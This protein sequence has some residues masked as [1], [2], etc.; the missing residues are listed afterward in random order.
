MT[1]SS[2]SQLLNISQGSQGNAS[3]PISNS[4]TYV[5]VLGAAASP[6]NATYRLTSLGNITAPSVRHYFS[7]MLPCSSQY[8]D[9]LFARVEAKHR[10]L[11]PRS[12]Y[13]Q[14]VAADLRASLIEA[15]K[16]P[17]GP[18]CDSGHVAWE[19]CY[20]DSSQFDRIGTARR[21]G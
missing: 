14:H 20:D 16:Q 21:P 7:A 12:P 5:L 19:S 18:N 1:A 15:L 3:L 10:T 4:Q 2:G 17:A 6:L 11:L 8:F 13:C 9:K